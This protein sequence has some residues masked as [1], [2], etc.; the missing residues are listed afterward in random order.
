MGGKKQKKKKFF[1]RRASTRPFISQI[2]RIQ[3]HFTDS[4]SPRPLY[5]KFQGSSGILEG[6]GEI[7][8]RNIMRSCQLLYVSCPIV[9]DP[10]NPKSLKFRFLHRAQVPEISPVQG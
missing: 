4:T 6:A 10:I 5:I 7:V 9:P 2:A 1:F 3:I 8:I